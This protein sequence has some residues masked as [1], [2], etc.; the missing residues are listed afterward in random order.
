VQADPSTKPLDLR[1]QPIVNLWGETVKV[2]VL[3][4]D[5]STLDGLSLT[6]K[7]LHDYL[8][9]EQASRYCVTL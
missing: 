1:Y 2:E 6:E 3:V 8:M 5:V 4:G 7:L 9:L